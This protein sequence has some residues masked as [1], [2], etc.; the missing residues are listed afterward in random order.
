M[1]R[2]AIQADAVC[3][4]TEGIAVHRSWRLDDTWSDWHPF[5]SSD[6]SEPPPPWQPVHHYH[7]QALFTGIDMQTAKLFDRQIRPCAALGRRH[8]TYSHS[9]L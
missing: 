9:L 8:P 6:E 4:R 2:F 3:A 1:A 7:L 5:K